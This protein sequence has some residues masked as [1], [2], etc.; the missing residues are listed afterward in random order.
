MVGLPGDRVIPG[1][2]VAIEQRGHPLPEDIVDLDTNVGSFRQD[3]A[4]G[5]GR[6]EG[7]RVVLEEGEPDGRVNDI[8]IDINHSPFSTAISAHIATDIFETPITAES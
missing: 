8:I 7:V 1:L 4:D 5:G 3:V 6:V 2:P